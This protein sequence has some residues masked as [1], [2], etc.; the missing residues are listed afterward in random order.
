MRWSTLCTLATLAAACTRQEPAQERPVVATVAGVPIYADEFLQELKRQSLDDEGS[1]LPTAAGEQA[2]RAALLGNLIEQR[3]VLREAERN[4]VLVTIDEVETAYKRAK[5]GWADDMF[6][7]HLRERDMTPTEFKAQLRDILA[8]RR[9]FTD[10]VFSRIAVTDEEIEDYIEAHPEMNLL[11]P[12]VWVKQIIVKTPE[13]AEAA[14]Q[15][16]RRG[17]PFEDAAMKYSLSPE[18]KTGGDMGWFAPGALPKVFDDVCFQLPPGQ[19]SKVIPS[20]YG[21]H[22]FYVVDRRPEMVRPHEQVRSEVEQLIRRQKEE[23]A[24]EM[25]LRELRQAT[26]IVIHDDLLAKL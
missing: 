7:A 20:E 9:Y 12:Q 15:E 3:L 24:Q 8:I 11:P 23:Q 19:V 18:A 6:V 2:H 22:L 10:H 14:A 13:E 1:A 21:F 16:I 4:N 25:R 5:T 26:D 17:M